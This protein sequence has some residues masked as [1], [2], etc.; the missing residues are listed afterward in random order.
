MARKRLNKKVIVALTL[1]VFASMIVLSVLMLR[2]LQHRDPQ[3]F[4]DQA[5]QYEQA[6]EWK[7]AFV[8]YQRAWDQSKD[9][10]YLVSVGNV[11]LAD[12]ELGRALASWRAALVNQPDL[13]DAHIRYVEVLLEMATLYGRLEDWRTVHEAVAGFLASAAARSAEQEA[14]ARH[15]DG[16]AL[17]ALAARD[18]DNLQRGEVELGRAVELA[19]DDVT[20]SLD[21]A[22]HYRLHERADEGERLYRS[23]IER[24]PTAGSDA[25]RVRVALA[26]YLASAGRDDEAEAAF[27]EGVALAEG[28]N[29]ALR[30]ARLEF[31]KFL[32]QRWAVLKQQGAPDSE[33]DP[34]FKRTEA[35]LTACIEDDG[36]A[37]EPYL[38]LAALYGTAGRH[39]DVVDI[40]ER[41]LRMGLSRTGV[42]GQ[43]NRLNAFTLMI[44][45]SQACVSRAVELSEEG[46][47][48]EH[49]AW[50]EKADR[51]LADARG[52]FPEH[53]RVHYQSGRLKL[54]RGLD[55]EALVDLRAADE[56]Y[57]TYARV[58]W[59]NK[60][61]L[62]RTHLRLNEAG[63]A[64]EVLEGVLDVARQGRG[65]GAGFWTLYAQVLLQVGELDRAM[66]I[67]DQILLVDTGNAD[68][69][70]IKAA[71]LERKGRSLAASQLIETASG[72]PVVG[73][74]LE[75]Q[76]LVLDGDLPGAIDVL[77][78]VLVDHP[79]DPRIVGAAVR[80]LLAADRADEARE[81]V[82]AALAVDP[83]HTQL[84]ALGVLTSEGLSSEQRDDAML[85][86]LGGLED[87]YQRALEMAGFFWRHG[88]AAEAIVQLDVALGHLAAKDTPLTK[89]TTTAQHRT[90]LTMKLS[91]A[92]SIDDAAAMAAARDEAVAANVDGVGGKSVIG[93]YH[94]HRREFE[95]AMA[96]L[97][98]ALEEQPTDPLTLV[99]LG[100]CLQLADRHDEA[101]PFYDRAVRA[102]PNDGRAH[103][104][105]AMLAKKRG[106][107]GAYAEAMEFCRRLLPDDPWVK[108]AL[109]A[110]REEQDPAGA[111]A[112]REQML[113]ESP[114]DL[115]NLERLA[116]LCSSAG[117]L[118]K[119]D[120]YYERLLALRPNEKDVVV[121]VSGHFRRTD[122]PARALA[123]VKAFTESRPTAETR[124]DAMILLASHYLHV[125][126]EDLVEQT[127]LAA[128]QEAETFE[129]SQAIAEFYLRYQGRPE[130]ALPWLDKAVAHATETNSPHLAKVMAAR[131]SCLLHP[132]L[133]D[134]D[135]ARQGVDDLLA[136]FPRNPQGLLLRSEVL[137]RSGR[138]D[139]AI[140]ALSDY[141]R[142]HPDDPNALYQ[143][144]LHHHA[145][146]HAAAT[147]ADLEAIKR[148]HPLALQLKPRLLL[149][150]LYRQA[151][152]P[153][154]WIHELE[155]V[156]SDAP[157]EAE[158]CEALVAA[159]IEEKRL[160]DAERVVSARINRAA[161]AAEPRWYFLRGQVGFESGDY[162]RA[163]ADFQRGAE[164][165][166][167]SAEGVRNVLDIYL[168]LDR[169]A[170]GIEYYGRYASSE[171]PTAGLLA[172]YARLLAKAGRVSEAVDTFRRAMSL[173]TA[174]AGALASVTTDLLAVWSPADATAQFEKQVV[175]DEL[176]R[177]N[178]RVLARLD[179]V[180][181]RFVDAARR[182]E[183]LVVAGRS[184]PERALLWQETGDVYQLG[185]R[186][187]E[188]R[189]A[190]K[191][192][193][194][195]DPDNWVTL[196]NMAYLLSDQIGE[197]ALALD[198]ARRAVVSAGSADTYDTLGWIHVG[199]KEYSQGIAALS[200]A[201]RLDS[202]AAL[203]YY[204]LGEAYRRDGQLSEASDV[205]HRGREILVGGAAIGEPGLLERI[206]TA[207]AR[208]QRS[209][210]AP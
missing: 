68:A 26:R 48:E 157:N 176:A 170:D 82:R 14:F 59:D 17:I 199:L 147:I 159:Y 36:E 75:S 19:P 81:V 95:P 45:A 11:L 32:S 153:D 186:P 49:D 71:A 187:E 197:H 13:T 131:V 116:R 101:G 117:E 78:R 118:D 83:E 73:R 6:G 120:R 141:L 173:A 184:G 79:A 42:T 138:I 10:R 67:C 29:P 85:R 40:S 84:Q 97:Q 167:F 155:R 180:A 160:A 196:N 54:A 174:D 1:S 124:A 137:S 183:G 202:E 177:A 181:G 198:Y 105:L 3:Y 208:V 146:G 148:L 195:E 23:L 21:L 110:D 12:G 15:A 119:A 37:Y 39:A 135:A 144:A 61:L 207:L 62:A 130:K 129:V 162:E 25:A 46:T 150:R 201:V 205:L 107:E 60:L 171:Q 166:G 178:E 41:R 16:L 204:H 113:A 136:R 65:V 123:V 77:R 7:S 34:L 169:P 4:V 143:R 18:R 139:G 194:E 106:D 156:V 151:G 90:L 8:F 168:R 33:T 121:M 134:V 145:M 175:P 2:Q 66:A 182:L 149:A 192:S 126:D 98:A 92:A 63:A 52:E 165:G 112:R 99:T 72:D 87:P 76:G 96:A 127:L 102:N 27:K 163:L 188:A 56:Q 74:L 69:V 103:R 80:V 114:D 122:R 190:Y 70:Q 30:D 51:Y 111:I 161:P 164:V 140:D 179:R 152:H 53:P 185:G 57:R 94:M 93:L 55:R 35:I 5:R 189:S 58:N 44:Y 86:V 109:L 210:T 158:P 115:A 125:H 28:E 108:A 31:A 200:R 47:R 38:Q 154:R 203:S 191:R 64:R 24:Y 209:E 132:S 43:R 88:D 9:A 133:G 193:V 89:N 22:D 142:L 128:A 104:G 206:D 50:L 91:V 20:Y 172:H 100:D